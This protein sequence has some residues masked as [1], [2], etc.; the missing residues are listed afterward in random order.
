MLKVQRAIHP[1]D[2][3]S[4][5]RTRDLIKRLPEAV[6]VCSEHG[7]AVRIR[8]SDIS[9]NTGAGPPFGKASYFSCCD[10]AIE[11]LINAIVDEAQRLA[12]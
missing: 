6:R 12:T 8:E 1:S 11:K 3:S 9:P 10:A 4:I 7:E 2:F 5:P